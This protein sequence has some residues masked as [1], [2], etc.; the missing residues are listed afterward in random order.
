MAPR[1]GALRNMSSDATGQRQPSKWRKRKISDSDDSSVQFQVKRD[2]IN[3]PLKQKNRKQDV[4]EDLIEDEATLFSLIKN[5]RA[6]LQVKFHF[7]HVL[8]LQEAVF[9]CFFQQ[10]AD[11]WIKKYEH[12]RLAATAELAQLFVSASGCKGQVARN[13]VHAADYTRLIRQMTE[14]FDEESGDYPLISSGA[15]WK[16]FRQNFS[17]F[18]QVLI[19]Q[20]QYNIIYDQYLMDH[21]LSFLTGLS[22]S[23][24]RAFRHTSTLAAVKVITALVSVAAKLK[25]SLDTLKRQFDA[26][27]LKSKRVAERLESLTSKRQQCTENNEEVMNMVTYM[28]RS[29]FIHRYR[30]FPRL[31]TEAN[32]RSLFNCVFAMHRGLATAAGEFLVAY[33]FSLDYTSLLDLDQ[34]DMETELAL[35]SLLNG[36]VHFAMD[37]ELSENA[38]YLV[39][40]LFDST[41]LL[42]EWQAMTNLLLNDKCDANGSLSEAQE[43]KLIEV[44]VC[45][46][47]QAATGDCPVGRTPSRRYIASPVAILNLLQIALY[48]DLEVYSAIRFDKHLDSLLKCIDDIFDKHTDKEL[49]VTCSK[50]YEYLCAESRSIQGRC[51][52]ERSKMIDTVVVKFR[53]NVLRFT[54]ELEDFDE[55]DLAAIIT[56]LK[57]IEA[58]YLCCDLSKYNLLDCLL[59]FVSSAEGASRAPHPDAVSISIR[60]CYQNLLWELHAAEDAQPSEAF[61]CITDLLLVFGMAVHD[62][63]SD[64]MP[65]IHIAINDLQDLL[66]EFVRRTAFACDAQEQRHDT[67]DEQALERLHINRKILAG[68][69]KLIICGVFSY[70]SAAFVLQHYAAFYNNYGDIMKA[71]LA[72]YR[73]YSKKSC[74]RA[75]LMALRTSFTEVQDSMTSNHIDKSSEKFVN[76]REL[77]KRLALSLGPDAIRSREIVANIHKEGIDFA[78]GIGQPMILAEPPRLPRNLVFFDVLTEFTHKLVKQDKR[79]LLSYLEKHT[80]LLDIT[81]TQEWQPFFSYRNSLIHGEDLSVI[82]R[83]TAQI[84]DTVS[85]NM[86]SPMPQDSFANLIPKLTSTTVR[87]GAQLPPTPLSEEQP[88]E[89][90]E[91]TGQLFET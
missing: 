57:K 89:E 83:V 4:I 2:R 69:C 80:S 42:K 75:M 15:Q 64:M 26:E 53:Q 23:Q 3:A 30:H 14:D 38:A 87:E 54:D 33:S 9:F 41:N 67:D 8:A 68:L 74:S 81:D 28:F 61:L 51:V 56:S 11:D 59:P 22:D 45:S 79:T 49:L 25:Q 13:L 24:V 39:D 27:R 88:E 37:N 71:I 70:D 63:L 85:Q 44:M 73:E 66:E 19:K 84:S 10:I 20:C 6:A 21:V 52:T 86:Q 32:A 47:K 16:R 29:V 62:F 60:C 90:S 18:V 35:A 17:D 40:A 72:R 58:L 76:L 82:T 5:G 46:V 77:A 65:A 50:V 55:D 91:T 31:L 7:F 12:D 1:S 36:L 48:F 43:A 78:L 34:R